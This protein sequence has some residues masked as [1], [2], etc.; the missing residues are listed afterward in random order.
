[1][2]GGAR[3]YIIS[4]G[5]LILI[6]G[7]PA[8]YYYDIPALIRGEADTVSSASMEIPDQPS[9]NF[10][11]LV[12]KSRHPDT[13]EE[14]TSFF[15]EKEVGVIMED[16]SCLVV[17]GDVTGNELAGRYQARLA[18]NQMSVRS[19][20]GTLLVS[21]AEN[22]LFDVIILSEEMADAYGYNEVYM[23][24]DVLSISISQS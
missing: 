5:I 20:D 9:G 2:M 21:R 12:N 15:T 11:V 8:I 22:A 10:V 1:M 14:W 23:R 3:H 17:K 19:E 4:L 6:L 16:I 13:L 7:L 24:D 18:E